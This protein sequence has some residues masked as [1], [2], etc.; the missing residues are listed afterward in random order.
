MLFLVRIGK[1]ALFVIEMCQSFKQK[2]SLF[3]QPTDKGDLF[4]ATCTSFVVG[5]G[6]GGKS[7]WGKK[8]ADELSPSLRVSLTVK[9]A[10]LCRS[11]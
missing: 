2:N 1:N 3:Q 5:T 10:V 8:F 9:T 11:N 4:K 7:I 6:K